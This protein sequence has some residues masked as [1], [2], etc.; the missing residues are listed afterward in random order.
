MLAGRTREA[1]RGLQT[2]AIKND[3]SEMILSDGRGF[4]ETVN[5][6]SM[7]RALSSVTLVFESSASASSATPAIEILNLQARPQSSTTRPVS[8]F[9][10]ASD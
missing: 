10:S 4:A 7:G 5:A 2:T 6:V 8:A 3:S 1:G 9:F